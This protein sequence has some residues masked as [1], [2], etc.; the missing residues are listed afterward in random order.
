LKK[1]SRLEVE[2]QIMRLA[3]KT[4][5]IT[6]A[7][8][9]IGAATVRRFCEEGSQV[10]LVDIDAD[11]LK[12]VMAEIER[13]HAKAQLKAL[14]L[15]MGVE[16]SSKAIVDATL[17]Q[18]GS[19]DIVVNNAGIRSYEA[20]I[21][22]KAET[23][24]KILSTNLLSYAFLSREALPALRRSKG[25]IVN[26]SSTHAVNPRAGMGQ[27]D[28]AKAGIL[29]LTR[30]LAFEEAPHQVRVNAVCPGLTLTPFHVRRF[31][32]QG[33]SEHDLRAEKV[34]HNLQ[35]RWADP[36]EV[37]HPIL[38]LASDE[39]SFVTAAT[40]MVDGGTRV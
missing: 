34:D 3:G 12:S 37:A 4:A 11:A 27:Y 24:Q 13:D 35:R 2:G 29:S 5:I 14:A 38:W 23:W 10:V 26:V 7:A 18:F 28:V 17:S 36:R 21:D 20:M 22:A 9:G 30:T 19:I 15:D 32:S 16:D 25:N 39:A 40:L 1:T 33:K 6:G 31:A 8:G